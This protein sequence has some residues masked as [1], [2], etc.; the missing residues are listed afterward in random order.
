MALQELLDTAVEQRTPT[1]F[2]AALDGLRDDGL[3]YDRL[4]VI[5]NGIVEGREFPGF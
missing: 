5:A 4:V 3:P 2:R 1:A